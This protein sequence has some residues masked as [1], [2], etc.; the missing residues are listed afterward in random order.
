M[1]TQKKK[2]TS[3][4]Y[5]C[6]RV[7]NPFATATGFKK[8]TAKKLG[9]WADETEDEYEERMAL[10]EEYYYDHVEW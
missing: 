6:P 10:E 7:K 9:A 1:A 5:L 3:R 4:R 2:R 8:A